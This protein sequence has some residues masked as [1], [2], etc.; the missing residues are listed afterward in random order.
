M[1]RT[2]AQRNGE[3]RYTPV[4]QSPVLEPQCVLYDTIRRFIRARFRYGAVWTGRALRAR[5]AFLAAD[6]C[7]PERMHRRPSGRATP[8]FGASFG[9]AE[10]SGSSASPIVRPVLSNETNLEEKRKAR[11]SVKN[12]FLCVYTGNGHELSKVF[13]IFPLK[14][15]G[16][17]VCRPR[18]KN[19][20]VPGG[21]SVARPEVT[22]GWVS[23]DQ[24]HA[25][26]VR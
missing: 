2:V 9:A 19:V 15:C 23:V 17:E 24:L 8:S 21:F 10:P 4:V 5:S 20:G 6:A 1:P 18:K 11:E 7:L 12:S 14:S 22:I 26:K 13:H 3:Q 16:L 25:R